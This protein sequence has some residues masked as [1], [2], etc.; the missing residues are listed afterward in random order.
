MKKIIKVIFSCS[1]CVTAAFA[2]TMVTAMANAGVYKWTDK[3]GNVHYGDKPVEQ[4]KSTEINIVPE[5]SRGVAV[6]ADKKKE[7]DR[8][9][10]EFQEDREAR[11]KKRDDKQAAQAKLKKQCAHA[12]DR[13]RRYREA[14]AVYKLDAKG[15][16]VF[17]SKEARA[18]KEKA[19][20]K[21][22]L[23]HC[24]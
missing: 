15:E 11:K 6:S 3:V 1:L 18:K 16:R 8:V 13:L 19:F 22:I 5:A 14:G 2:M 9:L 4:Q 20:N 12:K 7:R 10:E 17:Y 23:K 24:R 21:A